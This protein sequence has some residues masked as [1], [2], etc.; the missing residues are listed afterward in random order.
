MNNIY[1]IIYI[2]IL[3][4]SILLFQQGDLS[5]TFVSSYAY[6]QGHF[7]DFYEYNQKY[8]SGN[9]YLPIIYWIFAI[10]SAPLFFLD[11][12]TSADTLHH[13]AQINGNS[14]LIHVTAIEI[15][16]F[17]MLL[18]IFFV[19]TSYFIGKISEIINIEVNPS[20]K[21]IQVIFITSP[22]AIFP[23]FIFSQYDIFGVFF[24]IL[25]IYFL[26]KKRLIYFALFFSIAI[27]IKYF[28][29]IIFIPLLLIS[30][31]KNIEIIK[32]LLIGLAF[33]LFQF[34]LY[35]HS[36][37]FRGEIFSLVGGKASG[38]TGNF[39]SIFN[40][41]LYIFF[42]YFILCLFLYRKKFKSEESRYKAIV[43]S[44]IIGYGLMF[45][46]VVW[47]P[48]WIV[49][50]TPFFAL[51]YIYLRDQKLQA[52][53]DFLGMLAFIWICVNRWPHNV[54]FD[55]SRLGALRDLIPKNI[56]IGS[57]FFRP[58]YVYYALP[59]FYAYLFS[60]I[61]I[62]FIKRVR[63]LN[64]GII[65]VRYFLS[66]SIFILPAIFSISVSPSFA[67]K[68]NPYA[69]LQ[70]SKI[71]NLS[72]VSKFPT[73]AIMRGAGISQRILMEGNALSALSVKFATYNRQNLGT[74]YIT[75]YDNNKKTLFYRQVNIKD[76]LD[77]K[78]YL[79]KFPKN[80]VVSDKIINLVIESDSESPQ[81][82]ISVWASEY[83][84]S[85]MQAP[86][87][88]GAK[89]SNGILNLTLYFD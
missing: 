56:L 14:P 27:S 22:L 47:H 83:E 34:L 85:L 88:Q 79:L 9:D 12:A 10:W 21:I 73:G 59:V 17:K 11:L 72:E 36:S 78:Y 42:A 26:I 44:P 39:F 4:I 53:C 15:L 23:I 46:A 64:L 45:S 43:F 89:Q 65:Y 52:F 55:M 38:A 60:P 51:S 33:T 19:A 40:I 75:I 6:M 20:K 35:W 61:F 50:I 77:N 2:I 24:T 62:Y 8:L 86:Y 3:L 25:G 54:D 30:S 28:A 58:E 1:R 81:N 48:Q 13:L 29:L 67:E 63:C 70:F 16:W 71:Q 80:L 57:D 69:M 76:I 87:Y 32:L 49:L 5:H 66:I 82:S 31:K 68:I 74:L 18:G 37:V 41:N 84:A 7:S